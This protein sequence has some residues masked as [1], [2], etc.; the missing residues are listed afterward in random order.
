VNEKQ[1]AGKHSVVCDG[2]DNSGNKNIPL[3]K[4]NFLM[5]H[6]Y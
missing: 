1:V 2:K 3:V 4:V 6:N 5:A